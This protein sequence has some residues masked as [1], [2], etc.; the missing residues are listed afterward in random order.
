MPRTKIQLSEKPTPME[1]LGL[2]R[3]EYEIMPEGTLIQIIF[4]SGHAI[5]LT[6]PDR[7]KPFTAS[8]SKFRGWGVSGQGKT[9]E[10]AM[11][12]LEEKV[13]SNPGI[14]A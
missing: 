5:Q 7:N 14:G 2:L 1:M 6:H 12:A 4:P 8:V 3:T 9:A 13:Q 10:L 11:L